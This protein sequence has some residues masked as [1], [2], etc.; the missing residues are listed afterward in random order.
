MSAE[1]ALRV[2]ISRAALAD[3]VRRAQDAL[4]RDS[5][6]ARVALAENERH[7]VAHT[8]AVA[9]LSRD[10]FGHGIAVVAEVLAASGVRAARVDG[11]GRA[12]AAAA[13]ITAGED[14]PTL[15]SA[16]LYGFPRSG[17]TPVMRLAGT[18]LSTKRLLAGEGVSYNYTH[19]AERD[20]R[21]A[22]VA[23]G[24]GQGVMRGIGNHVSVEVGGRRCPIVGRVAMDVCVVDIGDARAAAG[25][26]VVY[27]GGDGLARD[28]LADWEHATGLTAAELA[29][30]VGLRV[31]R[32]DAA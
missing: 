3:N 13:G 21:I 24:F 11:A 10:A 31:R 32:Q 30:A 6:R 1:P 25:D 2:T 17:G 8:E 12:D 20:T 9:D 18:V 22:L 19:R 29:C 15:D 5:R 27:F 26:D 23:G 16:L 7:A 14:D 28:G 4:T